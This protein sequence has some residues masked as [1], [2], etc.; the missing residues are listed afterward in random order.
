MNVD[1][2]AGRQ[3]FS[4]G[5]MKRQLR[6]LSSVEPPMGLKE[7]LR[8]AIPGRAVQ[9]RPIWCVRWWPGM[10]GW[11]GIAAA[12]V[13]IGGAV[14]LGSPRGPSGK[15]ADDVNSGAGRVMVADYNS[16]RPADINAVDMNGIGRAQPY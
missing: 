10:V 8:A 1:S 6:G 2:R 13:V 12:I 16:V 14:W 4:A 11:K 7:R 9:A 3:E 5:W 15:P